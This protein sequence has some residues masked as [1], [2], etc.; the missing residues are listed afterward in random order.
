MSPNIKASTPSGKG[1]SQHALSGP[2]LIGIVLI[3]VVIVIVLVVILICTRYTRY[4]K[5]KRT[6]EGSRA[7]V[8]DTRRML[9]QV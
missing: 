8:K 1:S 3:I 9:Q 5:V 2:L 7:K 6:T 4:I